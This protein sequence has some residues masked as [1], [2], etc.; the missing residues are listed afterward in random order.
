MVLRKK[1][2]SRKE[3]LYICVCVYLTALAAAFIAGYLVR[4]WHSVAIVF[5]A[6]VAATIIV[7][8]FSYVFDNSSLYDPYWSLAPIIIAVYY[9]R[10]LFVPL[11]LD[12]W[13]VA[14]LLCVLLWGGRLTW[15]WIRHW[16]G[17]MHEDWRYRDIHT[18]TGV[19]YWPV[20]FLGIHLF[21]TVQVFLGCLC[22]YPVL[23]MKHEI[24]PLTGSAALFIT[25]GAIWIEAR[26][27]RELMDFAASGPAP[28]SI[29]S[30]GLGKWSRHPNYFGEVTFW[31]GLF[32]FSLS[33]GLFYWWTLAGPVA[34]H[35]MFLCVS[36]PMMD[37][38][39]L[40]RR[41]AFG[42]HIKRTRALIPLPRTGKQP[43]AQCD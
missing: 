38:R 43:E 30:A 11:S 42:K 34:I 28:R 7:F 41:P 15:N 22:L 32:L 24:N 13:R 39:L 17:M 1:N 3:S 27:D 2:Y 4:T 12:L 21:P 35:V 20:S 19:W 26:S 16:K 40:K 9:A 33:T 10:D 8:M 31:W 36:I 25:L 5:T 14:V 6:D 23:A 29:M 37:R 18:R